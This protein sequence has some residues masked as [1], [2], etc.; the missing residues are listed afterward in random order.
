VRGQ[1]L[2]RG[3]L[4]QLAQPDLDAEDGAH[5]RDDLR[6]QQRVPA[7]VEEA[8][9]EPTWSSP[10]SSHQMRERRCWLSECGAT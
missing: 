8:V 10:S 6:R 5:A 2:D 3:R 1:L 7:Q 9:G 4:E